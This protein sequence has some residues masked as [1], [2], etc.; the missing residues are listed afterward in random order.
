VTLTE[1]AESGR[2][3]H[4]T[5]GQ[6]RRGDLYGF[7][8]L[9]GGLRVIASDGSEWPFEGIPWEHVS[10]SLPTRCPTWDEM[11]FVKRQF[12]R[13]EDCVIQFHPPRSQY[14]NAHRYCLHLWKPVGIE[15]PLPPTLT[16]APTVAGGIL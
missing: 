5:L 6:T 3:D 4:P 2:R 12:W 1:L 16:L 15:L 9:R 11:C 10:V 13:D 8:E 14:V 7:F